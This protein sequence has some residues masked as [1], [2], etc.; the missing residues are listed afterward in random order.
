MTDDSPRAVSVEPYL[1][2]DL[3]AEAVRVRSALR[4]HREQLDRDEADRDRVIVRMYTEHGWSMEQIEE[5]WP[6][7]T[8]MIRQVLREHEE[9]TGTTV[10]RPVG[11]RPVRRH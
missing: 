4:R 6:R 1:R 2:D 11:R 10:R 9:T 5:W 7:S 8:T 3:M